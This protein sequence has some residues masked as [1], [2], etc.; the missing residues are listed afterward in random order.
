MNEL[1]LVSSHSCRLRAMGQLHSG[2]KIGPEVRAE[3][4]RMAKGYGEEFP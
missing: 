1:R 3:G 4:C 2:R